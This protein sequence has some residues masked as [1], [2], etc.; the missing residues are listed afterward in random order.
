MCVFEPLSGFQPIAHRTVKTGVTQKK[1][2]DGRHRSIRHDK[3]RN[4]NN[5]TK[6]VDMD[7]IIRKSASFRPCCIG[8]K[9]NIGRKKDQDSRPDGQSCIK[10]GDI[11]ERREKD[12]AALN[13][14]PDCRILHSYASR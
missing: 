4:E 10:V 1:S 13:P 7:E 9:R 11:N 14:L 8:G 12:S 6:R 5:R 2:A 3:A